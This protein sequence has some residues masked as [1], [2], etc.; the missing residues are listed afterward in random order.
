MY[1]KYEVQMWPEF[2]T[3]SGYVLQEFKTFLFESYLHVL[4]FE[5]YLLMHNAI[6]NNEYNGIQ[7]SLI[8]FISINMSTQ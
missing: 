3:Q 5:I 6:S 4:N 1:I 2:C 8:F 7:F